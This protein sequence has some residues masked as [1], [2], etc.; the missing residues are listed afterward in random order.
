[1]SGF[2][3]ATPAARPFHTL[4]VGLERPRQELYDRIDR[5][6]DAMLAAGL[7]QEAGALYPH[8]EL[9][10]LQ[11]VGYQEIFG[12]MDRTYDWPEAV[13][14]LKRNTRR[15]A[16]RQLTWFRRDASIRWFAPGAY[17]AMVEYLEGEI[18][19]ASG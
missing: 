2:R 16:K 5:R 8:R 1:F 9:P 11:T 12:W 17:A 7:R 3:T 10:A 13:R 19:Q 6:V 4:Q 14:R 18:A 15:Y